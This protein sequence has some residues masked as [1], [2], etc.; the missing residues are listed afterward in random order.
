M[1]IALITSTISPNLNA[2]ALKVIDHKQRLSEYKKSFS[3]YS[4][5]LKSGVFDKLVYVDNSGHSLNDIMEIAETYNISSQV[6]F[7]SYESN[8]NSENNSRF[9]LELNLINYTIENSKFIRNNKDCILWKITGRYV[10]KNIDEIIRKCKLYEDYEL[11]LNYR[12]RPSK[13]VDFYLAGFSLSAFEKIFIENLPLY[14]GKNNGENILRESIDS[15]DFNEIKTL[16]RFPYIPYISGNRGYDGASYD[17]GKSI[18]KYY[19]RV[20]LNKIFPSLWI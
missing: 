13:W 9:Y 2:V 18:L 7:I 17:T 16:K 15:P 19:I 10:I 1:H 6:E 11:F 14:K 3:F 20:L 12:N 4:Q 5:A 8:L